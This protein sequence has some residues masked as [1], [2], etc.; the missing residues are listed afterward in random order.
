[1][2]LYA[3]KVVRRNGSVFSGDAHDISDLQSEGR[4]P[5]QR[6][7]VGLFQ[8]ARSSSP[9]AESSRKPARALSLVK[10]NVDRGFVNGTNSPLVYFARQP[11]KSLDQAEL[12]L[13][14]RTAPHGAVQ[15]LR[16]PNDSCLVESPLLF[17][18]SVRH[19]TLQCQTRRPT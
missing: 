17:A 18:Y 6:R 3:R 2:T 10:R 7:T 14:T 12:G 9:F 19:Q 15:R 13:A 8:P 1:M 11:R 5:T 4:D 16:M